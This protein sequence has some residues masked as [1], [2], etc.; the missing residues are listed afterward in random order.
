MMTP[1]CPPHFPSRAARLAR[2]CATLRLVVVALGAVTLMGVAGCGG[3]PES[4]P[5]NGSGNAGGNSG[6]GGNSAGAGGNRG[7]TGGASGTNPDGGGAGGG[8][9]GNTEAASVRFCNGVSGSAGPVVVEVQIGNN[10]A[11]AMTSACAS[12]CLTVPAGTNRVTFRMNGAEVF[13][14]DVTFEAGQHYGM[15]ASVD[16]AQKVGLGG[17]KLPA[18]Q[19]CGG[20]NP[21]GD[22]TGGKPLGK[23]C[24]SL[25]VQT[26]MGGQGMPVDLE[27]AVGNV[28]FKATSGGCSSPAQQMCIALPTGPV[29]ATLTH[30]G[31]TIATSQLT[32]DPTKAYLLS[33]NVDGGGQPMITAQAVASATACAALGGMSTMPMP[34]P[35]PNPDAKA[36]LKF[37]NR[38]TAS[39]GAPGVAEIVTQD[40]VRFMARPG[41]CAPAKGTACSKV[42]AGR[43]TVTLSIDGT[44]VGSAGGDFPADR[45]VV[46]R[47]AL[48][49]TGE[50]QFTLQ[51]VPTGMVCADYEPM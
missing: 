30:D 8:S 24:H 14:Q 31:Q 39:A 11:Q 50:P 34:M 43:N 37:C 2:A 22:T 23:F 27:L 49:A 38:M 9:G 3:D 42:A 45:E 21:F 4:P 20:Y 1:G 12:G 44:E 47:L 13:A 41:Q 5:S 25:R 46:L 28:L 35:M 15:I 17:G 51:S 16:S 7:G 19:Q 10:K 29:T 33:A 40:G 48:S 26:M 36:T 6:S 32:F 18:G